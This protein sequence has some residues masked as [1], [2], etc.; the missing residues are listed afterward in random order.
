M[1]TRKIKVLLTLLKNDIINDAHFMSMCYSLL[2]MFYRFDIVRQE[3]I[4][5]SKYLRKHKCIN[6]FWFPMG[7]KQ[8][9]IEWLDEQINKPWYKIH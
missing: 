9:R 2:S 7:E 6:G 5:I 1:K 3:Y 8:P 4:K